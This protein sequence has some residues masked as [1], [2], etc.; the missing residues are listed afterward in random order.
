MA[1]YTQ[2]VDNLFAS[3]YPQAVTGSYTLAAGQGV[4]KRG[5]LIA[6]GTGDKGSLVSAAL[7]ANTPVFVLAD[8]A[9]TGSSTSG[10]AVECLGY[11][12]GHFLDDQLITGSSYAL[13]ATDLEK[14]RQYGIYTSTGMS[15]QEA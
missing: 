1:T 11:R 8:D 9:D 6:I 10:S 13:K 3:S 2:P 15:S 4:L 12:A 7:A 14:M 5:S